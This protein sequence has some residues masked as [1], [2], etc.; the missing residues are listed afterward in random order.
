MPQRIAIVT[1]AARGIGAGTARRLASNGMAVAV[2]DLK[3]DDGARTVGEIEEAGGRAIAVGAD[4]S[5]ADQVQAA[6]DKIVAELGAPTVLV[7]N[8]G[9]TRDNLLFKMSETDWDTVLG[10][11]LKGAFL[12]TRAVQKYMVGAKW[13]R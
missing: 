7:N 1:G 4:V 6:V 10:V 13:G 3:E 9:V 12:M 2:L 11:H 8:A 5:N